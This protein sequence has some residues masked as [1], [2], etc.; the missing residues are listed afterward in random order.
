M[1]FNLYL[2]LIDHCTF[3]LLFL[4]L[5]IAISKQTVKVNNLQSGNWEEL[6]IKVKGLSNSKIRSD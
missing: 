2:K 5:G 4:L 1:L 3:F 6:A